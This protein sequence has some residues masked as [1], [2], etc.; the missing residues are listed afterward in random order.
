MPLLMFIRH[1]EN[2]YVKE[3]KLAGRLPGVHL[4]E[5]GRKQAS[6]LAQALADFKVKAI[7]SSPL[8]R[9]IETAQPISSILN[10]PINISD[11]LIEVDFGDWTGQG[12]KQLRKDALWKM[13]QQFPSL[14]R[15]PNGESFVEAQFRVCSL[16]EKK[17][18]EY[19][20]KDIIL[21]ISHSDVIK[22]AVVYYIGLGLDY[23]QRIQISPS[24][25][26][27]LSIQKSGSILVNLNHLSHELS[28]D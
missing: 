14:M 23:F 25:I 16:V 19:K 10:L 5:A 2:D 12:L 7:Y 3:Q 17:C 24:S 28:R 4:N 18:K 11:D 21:C 1:G 15:F 6:L 20:P 8:D 26:T 13:V 9:A 27:T 22:L